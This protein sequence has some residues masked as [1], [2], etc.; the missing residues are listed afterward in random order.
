MTC[1]GASRPVV[2]WPGGAD[3]FSSAYNP[4]GRVKVGPFV[5]Q[6]EYRPFQYPL[7]F[8]AKLIAIVAPTRKARIPM[9]RIII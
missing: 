5:S 8:T 1:F 9:H 2:S 7:K 3:E 4:R 6:F